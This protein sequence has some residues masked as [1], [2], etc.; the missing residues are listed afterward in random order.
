MKT[1]S[2]PRQNPEQLKEMPFLGHLE[3]LRRLII[4]SLI[5]IFS[6]TVVCWFFSKYILNLLIQGLPVESLYFLSP[7]EA[8]TVRMRISLVCGLMGAFPFVLF[9]V[10]AFVAPA[11]FSHEQRRVYPLIIT[12]SIL[13]YA[14]VLF[15]YVVLIPIVLGFLLSFGTEFL[16]PLISVKSYFAFVARLC[17]TFGVV[18]QI[19]IVV[20]VLSSLGLVTPGMLLRQWRYGILVIVVGS[21]VLTPPDVISLV[22]MAVPI[23][24]LYI[25]SI[26]VAYIVVRKED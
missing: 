6:L 9:K 21:A 17:F 18:F 24:L 20:L 15:C 22:F 7:L 11:L 13:F 3:E 10:W 2:D 23:L 25:G 5:A 19:P 26:L 14:G 4:H 8:F 1:L 16:N 12:S